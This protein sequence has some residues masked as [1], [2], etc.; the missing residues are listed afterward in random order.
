MWSIMLLLNCLIS[1][2]KQNIN[3]YIAN[4]ISQNIVTVQLR[5]FINAKN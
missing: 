2:D 3:N 4:T 1:A 5:P